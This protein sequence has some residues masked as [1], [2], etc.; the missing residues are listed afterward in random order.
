MSQPPPRGPASLRPDRRALERAVTVTVVAA[1]GRRRASSPSGHRRRR[2]RRGGHRA[3]GDAAPRRDR[4]RAPSRRRPARPRHHD[5]RHDRHVAR[6]ADARPPTPPC[7]PTAERAGASCSASTSS[8]SGWSTPTTGVKRTYPVSGSVT[9]NL[10]PGTYAVYSRS[11]WAIGVD[12]SGVMQYF[13]RFTQGPTGAAIGFHTIPTQNGV[14]LQTARAAR[15]AA[16]TRLHPAGD[17]RRDRAVELRAGRHQGRRRRLSDDASPAQAGGG[18]DQG[19]PNR[20]CGDDDAGCGTAPAGRVGA[21]G[22]ARPVPWWRWCVAAASPAATCW[23]PR[24]RERDRSRARTVAGPR[25]ARPPSSSRGLGSTGAGVDDAALGAGR[26]AEVVEEVLGGRVGL[27]RL[28]EGQVERLVDHL[29]AVEVGPVHEGD[30]DAGGAGAAGAA[31]PVDVGLLVLGAGVVDD[32]G[33]ARRRR[34]RGRRRRWRRGRGSCPR[35][36][37]SA[38]SRGRPGPCRRAAA[39][40]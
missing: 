20:G 40:R 28:V 26:D 8:G 12:D 23:P 3:A 1:L 29:P 39:R 24:V 27:L 34:C 25:P 35:G 37:W 17:A 11:R 33:D 13:V 10:Q 7:R 36:T 2:R 6:A 15:H 14:P 22:L 4:R 21:V 38:P 18:S 16:V 5:R 31:D 19:W 30:R 32:V 9:D